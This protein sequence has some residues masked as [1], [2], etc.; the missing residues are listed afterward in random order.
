MARS[1]E[2]DHVEIHP[3]DRQ[4]PINEEWMTIFREITLVEELIDFSRKENNPWAIGVQKL[5]ATILQNHLAWLPPDTPDVLR[6]LCEAVA[7]I[8]THSAL[9][10][11]RRDID[12]HWYYLGAA[13]Q[14]RLT[15]ALFELD[16]HACH[17]LLNRTARMLS[18]SEERWRSNFYGAIS[19]ARTARALWETSGT[20]RI[21]LATLQEDTHYG[22]D[23]HVK[24]NGTG[25]Y[26]S[27]KSR[28]SKQ[29]EVCRAQLIP[30]SSIGKQPKRLWKSTGKLNHRYRQHWL[31]AEITINHAQSRRS[32]PR[33][34]SDHL[35]A[36]QE[37]LREAETVFRKKHPN[38]RKHYR[39]RLLY[40]TSS[41]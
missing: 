4:V 31:P 33:I 18:V 9:S 17:Y 34:T 11:E 32:D 19:A 41:T 7:L 25:L 20:K 13:T 1:F 16:K 3:P 23:L 26:I 15:L 6:H 28:T 22:I 2:Q 35:T 8:Q 10:S 38:E 36:V 21:F 14:R 30:A 5:Y 27:V 39:S 29:G 37:L 24:F 12:I 40:D